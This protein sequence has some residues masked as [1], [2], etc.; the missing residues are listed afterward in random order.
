MGLVAIPGS[1]CLLE[2]FASV[3]NRAL[4]LCHP[5][6]IDSLELRQIKS[7]PNLWQIRTFDNGLR[8]PKGAKL[9]REAQNLT[10]LTPV[11]LRQRPK[12]EG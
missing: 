8:E 6:G 5:A 9:V 3:T 10:G 1:D 4:S 7:F 11:D 12:G 2:E